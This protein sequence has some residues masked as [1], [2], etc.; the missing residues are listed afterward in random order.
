MAALRNHGHQIAT[1][2]DG[3]ITRSYHADGTTLQKR[4]GGTWKLWRRTGLKGDLLHAWLFNRLE[5]TKQI[6]PSVIVNYLSINLARIGERPDYTAL[7][8]EARAQVARYQARQH[9][10]QAKRDAAWEAGREQREQER[11]ERE[12]HAQHA[13]WARQAAASAICCQA[14][15]GILDQSTTVLAK[16][17]S[18]TVTVQNL[19]AFH[20]SCFDQ[21]V[22]SGRRYEVQADGRTV[23]AH[24]W[25]LSNDGLVSAAILA[26]RQPALGAR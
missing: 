21:L 5:N 15:G 9:K 20:G 2:T 22:A 4:R 3:S 6:N 10:A 25:R 18:G 24:L 13:L 16:F 17:I 26:S 12:R 23:P 19:V 8:T 7:L 1:L 11:Q 14:C